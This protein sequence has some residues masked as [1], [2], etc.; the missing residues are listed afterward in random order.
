MTNLLEIFRAENGFQVAQVKLMVGGVVR[1]HDADEAGGA[2]RESERLQALTLDAGSVRNPLPLL[3]I[4]RN[5][6]SFVICRT[7]KLI[8]WCYC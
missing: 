3:T 7:V 5:L 2:G 8:R 6:K 1:S 4:Y